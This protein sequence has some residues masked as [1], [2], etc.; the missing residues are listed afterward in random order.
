MKEYWEN[1]KE[2]I[3]KAKEPLSDTAW[4]QMEVELN[5]FQAKKKFPI[6]YLFSLIALTSVFIYALL[7]QR[8]ESA[9]NSHSQEQISFSIELD[10]T[11]NDYSYPLV[12][13]SHNESKSPRKHYNKPIAPASLHVDISSPSKSINPKINSSKL[14]SQNPEI[15]TP[16]QLARNQIQKEKDPILKNKEIYFEQENFILHLIQTQFGNKTSK[17][18]SRIPSPMRTIPAF[19]LKIYA[20]PKFTFNNQGYKADE[21][22]VNR[23]YSNA[24]KGAI[25]NSIGYESG[26]ELYYR[27]YKNFRIGSGFVI[28]EISS[29]NSFNYEIS[30]IPVIEGS[31]GEILAYITLPES[32]KVEYEGFNK[33]QYLSIPLSFY[34]E[35]RISPQWLYSLEAVQHFGFL[36]QYSST[37]VNNKTLELEETQ[38]SQLSSF[39]G[40][41]SLSWAIQYQ[42][43]PRLMIGLEPKLSYVNQDIFNQ[44]YK[45]WK[46][47]QFG[48][49]LT[50]T[51]N[52]TNSQ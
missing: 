19:Q 35:K 20:G 1:I 3:S 40:S 34:Y 5:K 36:N 28:Q 12:N 24:V 14:D 2:E 13:K 47:L 46:P 16:N 44:E 52:I 30:E 41:S 50:T 39:I 37:Q 4:S 32:R 23:N 51:L 21:K 6:F 49:N 25:S 7:Y 10:S 22:Q 27:F 11:L 48:I 45:S 33:F 38:N 42:F 8:I 29:F 15:R 43:S 31:S 17:S 9:P 18:L 26:V